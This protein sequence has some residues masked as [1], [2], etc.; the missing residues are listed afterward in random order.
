MP[1]HYY[2]DN[3][4]LCSGKWG[5]LWISVG[6]FGSAFFLMDMLIFGLFISFHMFVMGDDHHAP[7]NLI[8]LLIKSF[9][10]NGAYNYV[11]EKMKIS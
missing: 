8:T 11:E 6:S 9:S 3:D 5:S 7:G 4:F 10:E 1:I 2:N